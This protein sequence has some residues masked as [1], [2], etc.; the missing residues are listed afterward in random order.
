M[1]PYFAIDL[2]SSALYDPLLPAPQVLE[3][4][5]V[6]D[7]CVSSIDKLPRFNIGIY[8]N[9]IKGTPEALSMTVTLIEMMCGKRKKD[10]DF[11]FPEHAMEKLNDFIYTHTKQGER[12]TLAGKNVAG[13][14]YPV[15]KHNGWRP[16]KLN[17]HHRIIDV[18]SMYIPDFGYI[19]SLSE[20][21]KITG[22][23][24]VSHRAL[25]EC[26]DT[27]Y[28]VRHKMGIPIYNQ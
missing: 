16:G 23:D 22:R 9:L 3:I 21:N 18:G 15:L 20:I 13:F 1:K 2:E 4:A 27:I 19:P 26:I 7:D 5:C 24:E 11:I 28:A 14:D 6:Y 25:S 8:H 12:P 10:I 17:I